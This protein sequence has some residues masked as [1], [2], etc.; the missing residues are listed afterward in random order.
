MKE[1]SD[2][3]EMFWAFADKAPEGSIEDQI[4]WTVEKVKG[5][6]TA[7]AAP[8]LKAGDKAKATQEQ[9]AVL[10][11]GGDKPAEKVVPVTPLG[12]GDAFAQIQ[13]RI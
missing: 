13:R 9:N 8:L 3:S 11:R 10:E 6:K 4:K 12:L 5:I 7:I 2:D 1:G